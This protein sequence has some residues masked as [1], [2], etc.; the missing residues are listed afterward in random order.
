MD[1]LE[2]G[3][4]SRASAARG[5]PAGFT[6][7]FNTYIFVR[8]ALAC[9]ALTWPDISSRELARTWLD[10]SQQRQLYRLQQRWW[11]AVEKAGI[12]AWACRASSARA[13]PPARL[14]R[15]ATRLISHR[16]QESRRG[17]QGFGRKPPNRGHP[18]CSARPYQIKALVKTANF[19]CAGLKRLSL[20][21]GSLDS[22]VQGRN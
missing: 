10:M 13:A 15:D 9:T 12:R 20:A 3:A 11:S 6:L 2:A 17:D 22:E 5:V 1:G 7:H 16:R 18:D 21:C 4:E 19:R 8:P 14:P